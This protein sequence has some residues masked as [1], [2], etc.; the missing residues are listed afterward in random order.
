MERV[1]PTCLARFYH[2]PLA[3]HIISRKHL[4]THSKRM[5]EQDE[6]ASDHHG[7]TTDEVIQAGNKKTGA[8]SPSKEADAKNPWMDLRNVL[9]AA[10]LTFFATKFLIYENVASV[11]PL[12]SLSAKGQWFYFTPIG[13]IFILMIVIFE[14]SR[15]TKAEDLNR[16]FYADI[17]ILMFGLMA[18]QLF[19]S[20]IQA[21][22][23]ALSSKT[24]QP[25]IRQET[26]NAYANFIAL[27]NSMQR[28][29]LESV[30]SETRDDIANSVET[31]VQGAF[32]SCGLHIRSLDEFGLRLF[33][34]CIAS[35]AF[36]LGVVLDCVLNLA[37][38]LPAMPLV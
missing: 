22:P 37:W 32:I 20:G 2:F 29:N 21:I 16:W 6:T 17:F 4:P 25:A 19:N 7:D 38:V 23:D 26:I 9:F 10:A 34:A 31:T 1:K 28:T 8:S 35:A 27:T 30:I 36:F 18:L 11:T 15:I 13:V 24:S 14:F 5:N 12:I 3:T 33:Y